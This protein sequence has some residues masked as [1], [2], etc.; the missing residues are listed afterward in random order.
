MGS[1]WETGALRGLAAGVLA[2]MA[3]ASAAPAAAQGLQFGPVGDGPGSY[4]SSNRSF[5]R[6]W[7]ANPPKGFPTI[8]SANIAPTKAAIERYEQIV[9][10]GGFPSVPEVK[11]EPAQTDPAVAILS[12]RL[13]ASRDL[14]G[15]S[16]ASDYSHSSPE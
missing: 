15:G 6:Q 8:S 14:P 7:Q 9:K 10:D 12:R 4:G 16:S 11:L 3:L 13:A 1:G 2:G 5:A